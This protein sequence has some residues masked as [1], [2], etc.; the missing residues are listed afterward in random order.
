MGNV[1]PGIAAKSAG[2]VIG[3]ILLLVC[4]YASIALGA[5]KVGFNDVV[6]SFTN[7]DESSNNQIII[8]TSRMPRA[9]IA[10]AIGA[11]LAIAGALIQAITRNPLADPNV[12]GINFGASFFVVLAVT[13]L[14]VSSTTSIMWIAFLGAAIGAAA[15]YLLGSVGRDG[16][17]PLKIIMAGAALSALFSSFTQ[18]MLV[19]DE[20][21]L[22]A[23]LFWLTGSVAG[24][25]MEMLSAVWP[26]MVVCWLAALLLA[27]HI[28]VLMMGDDAAKG[29]GQRTLAVKIAAGVIIGILAGC[30]VAVAGPVGFIGMVIP[31]M[32][33]FFAGMDY[34]WIIPYSAMLGAILLLLSDIAARFAIMPEELPVGVVTALIGI[35]FFIYVARRGLEKS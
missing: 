35:P 17:T 27:R 26:F 22:D 24:R 16:L 14:S 3:A 11:S 18:G 6:Q 10:A 2:I 31:Y 15:A 25:T 1:L 20:Q 19:L 5:T 8:K 9:F 33:R 13:V 32:A 7:Y 12:L 34:R 29:L 21:G 23:V 28:N 4:L 30:S